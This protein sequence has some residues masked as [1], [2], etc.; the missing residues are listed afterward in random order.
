MLRK[1]TN[2]KDVSAVERER[3]RE[4]PPHRDSIKQTDL[5]TVEVAET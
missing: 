1:A 4:T 3:E 5:Y 2:C